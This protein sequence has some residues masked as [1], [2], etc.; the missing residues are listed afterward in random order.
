MLAA[1]GGVYLA[2]DQH[3]FTDQMTAGRGFIAVAAVIFGRWIQFAPRSHV[4]FS[5]LLKP[6]RFSCREIISFRRSLWR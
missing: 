6:C 3:Q 1:L 5:R 4:C 2:L